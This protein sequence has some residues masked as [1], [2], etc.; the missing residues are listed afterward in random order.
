ML[1][2]IYAL[3][4]SSSLLANASPINANRTVKL[5]TYD[6]HPAAI[7]KREGCGDTRSSNYPIVSMSD[8]NPGN[9]DPHQNYWHVQLSESI[10]CSQ[11]AGCQVGQSQTTSITVDWSLASAADI[12]EW[13]T[14]GFDVSESWTTGNSYT[15]DGNAGETVCIWQNVAHTAYSVMEEEINNCVGVTSSHAGVIR[16]PNSNNQGGGFYC[17]VGTCG[18]QGDGYWEAGCAGGPQKNC[19]NGNVIS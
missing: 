19:G 12:T 7:T 14:A 9:G 16:S 10:T 13:F 3:I 8:Q 11:D 6:R 2:L 4:A 5:P 18:D 1:S 15:C 17:V